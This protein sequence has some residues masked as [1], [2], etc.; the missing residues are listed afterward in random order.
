MIHNENKLSSFFCIFFK[1]DNSTLFFSRSE[2]EFSKKLRARLLDI[3]PNKHLKIK[4]D[5]CYKFER[6][7]LTWKNPVLWT[8]S[9]IS[10]SAE[11]LKNT[12]NLK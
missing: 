12:Q 7:Y 9:Q 6:I 5:Y 10:G 3:G 1:K 11:Y 8:E 2:S 4:T